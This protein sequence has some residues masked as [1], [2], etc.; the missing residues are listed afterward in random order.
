MAYGPITGSIAH[1]SFS[2]I[3]GY[4][5]FYALRKKEFIFY[6]NIGVSKK[7]LFFSIFGFNLLTGIPLL[8]VLYFLWQFYQS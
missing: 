8:S 3:L 5:A 6:Q 4:F 1:F 7:S 2:P